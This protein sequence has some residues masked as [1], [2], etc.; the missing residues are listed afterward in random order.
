[1]RKLRLLLVV[2]FLA[3]F[4]V[5]L[6]TT[7][8]DYLTSDDKP[9]V[10]TADQDVVEVSVSVSD[11]ELLAGM[12]AEDNLDGNVTDSLVV[13]SKS[14]F[15]TKGTRNVNYAA[16]D[17]NNNVGTYTRKVVYTDYH[18][19][20]FVMTEPL[21]F[22]AGNS[23]YD[24]LRYLHAEDCLDGDI[25]SQIKVTFG[26]TEMSSESVSVQKV[27][28][29]V[30]NSAGDSAVLEMTATFE[31]YDSYSKASP[32]LSD[33]IIYVEKGER[34][35]YR[36]YL[37]GIWTAGNFRKF[38]DLGFDPDTDVTVLEGGVDYQ[39]PGV[40]TVTYRLT[41]ATA[42]ANGGTFRTEFGTATM[43][44]VVEDAP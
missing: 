43:I 37:T 30:T 28:V 11:E 29:Q 39:T 32:A 16:F 13:V 38:S 27:N 2:F 23:S 6:G 3:V 44:V 20:H 42:N 15:I 33:Y 10:I 21:R 34:P 4:A 26:E 7:I 40:Y 36:S 24:Y 17:G 14:K 41:R 5:F 18:S 22:V 25:S 9:P 1:M 35:N 12:K 19:P 8:R 31:D